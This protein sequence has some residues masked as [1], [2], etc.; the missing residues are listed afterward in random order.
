MRSTSVAD[1]RVDRADVTRIIAEFR[2]AMRTLRCIGSERLVRLGISMTQLHVVSILE[3]HGE[4]PMNRLAELLDVSV[5]NATGL[6]DRMEE[7]GL[8][9]RGRVPD[10]R[11][12]VLVRVTERGRE[13]LAEL[14]VLR[15]DLVA[16]VLA[17]L[18]DDQLAGVAR[19]LAD[20]RA[21]VG[22]LDPDAVEHTHGNRP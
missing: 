7:R 1:P 14:E 4:V 18:D 16:S 6:I 11:R 21:A 22:E 20:V 5:S 17:R 10:D 2:S 15:D 12:V 19:A 9:E 3:R 13:V 8:V